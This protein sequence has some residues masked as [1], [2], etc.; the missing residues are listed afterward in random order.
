MDQVQIESNINNAPSI[1][2]Q[3]ASD[4]DDSELR[5]NGEKRDLLTLTKL[6][7]DLQLEDE[8]S[9]VATPSEYGELLQNL[10][11]Y[12]LNQSSLEPS[13]ISGMKS[14]LL[15]QQEEVIL[16]NYT[17][18]I[19]TSECLEDAATGVSQQYIKLERDIA[20]IW[21]WIFCFP[22]PNYY[23]SPLPFSL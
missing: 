5:L 23:I 4:T 9:D 16:T 3:S 7:G 6:T 22:F 10:Y 13:R 12:T 18:L 19:N 17:S 15:Q 2:T 20:S 14:Q 21:L 8:L 11:S 1:S